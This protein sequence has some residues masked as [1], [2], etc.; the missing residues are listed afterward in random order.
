MYITPIVQ[1]MKN[2]MPRSN[3]ILDTMLCLEKEN[4]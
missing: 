3:L 1:K 2:I 4:L